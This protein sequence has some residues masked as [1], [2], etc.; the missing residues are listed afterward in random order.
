MAIA[1]PPF[2]SNPSIAALFI[3][4]YKQ[5]MT[6]GAQAVQTRFA[7]LAEHTAAL[8]AAAAAMPVYHGGPLSYEEPEAAGESYEPQPLPIDQFRSTLLESLEEMPEDKF[9]AMANKIATETLEGWE[10]LSPEERE[11]LKELFLATLEPEDVP[12]ETAAPEE[13]ASVKT[14]AEPPPAGINGGAP[15]MINGGAERV[16]LDPMSREAAE[17]VVKAIR[18]GTL[19]NAQATPVQ[20]ILPSPDSKTSP[21]ALPPLVPLRDEGEKTEQAPEPQPRLS[22]SEGQSAGNQ[23][24]AAED[25]ATE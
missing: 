8:N 22:S 13:P 3:M 24:A 20:S 12:E 10:I 19:P 1:G 21:S 15:A 6:E 25:A 14:G 2:N 9:L 17:E 11:V 5:A 23:E 18:N 7:Q 4:S 16:E